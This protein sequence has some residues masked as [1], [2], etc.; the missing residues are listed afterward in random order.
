MHPQLTVSMWLLPRR[1]MHPNPN[2][3]HAPAAARVAA[4]KER[5]RNTEGTNPYGHKYHGTGAN[6]G[7]PVDVDWGQARKAARPLPI[8]GVPKPRYHARGGEGTRRNWGSEPEA[9]ASNE[10]GAFYAKVIG[11]GYGYG[12]PSTHPPSL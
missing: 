5:E 11:Y 2:P 10:I 9:Q 6:S 4:Q 1:C 7:A 8:S 12:A 3:N